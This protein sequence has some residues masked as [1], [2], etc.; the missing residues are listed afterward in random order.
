MVQGYRRFAA[1]RA[2]HEEDGEA[3]AKIPAGFLPRG[4]GRTKIYRRMVDENVIR[5]DLSFPEMAM[6]AQVYAADPTTSTSSTALS[7]C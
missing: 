7:L 4:E 1:Y 2:L 6:T 5:K 3:W